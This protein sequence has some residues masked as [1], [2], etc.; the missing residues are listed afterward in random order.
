MENRE[1][2][3]QKTNQFVSDRTDMIEIMDGEKIILR[4]LDQFHGYEELKDILRRN[5]EDVKNE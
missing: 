4:V 5:D 1:I 2:L 3:E